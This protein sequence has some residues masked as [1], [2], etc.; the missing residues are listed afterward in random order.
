M[1]LHIRYGYNLKD[2]HLERILSARDDIELIDSIESAE[3]ILGGI[4]REE[5]NIAKSLKWIQAT[6]AGVDGLLFP[7]LVE[8]DVIVTNASGIHPIPIAEHTF[9]LIL[10]ITRGLIKS[11]EGKS[12]RIWLHNEVYIDEL[13]GKTI[14]IIGY[15]RIG[16]GIARLAKGFG[17]KVIGLKRDPEK[18]LEV[19]PDI[20]LGKDSLDILLRESDVIVIVVPLTEETYHLIGERELRLMK[21]SSILINVARGK[22][23]DETALIRALKEK[24][25]LGAG[26]DVFETE[27]LPPESELWN[28]ENVVI[29]PH[30][31]GLNPYYTDRLLEIFIK[32]LKAYPDVSRMINVVDKRLGY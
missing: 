12:K 18:E 20:L 6:G 22:V 30:I 10:A 11:F 27:P 17:M 1:K 7:E 24:W 19:K 4:S 14:G 26:L 25:I 2:H 32:N 28:L 31:A 9:A 23:I 13:Y 15:G 16:Q 8:S 3:V 5:F 29:T 21:P